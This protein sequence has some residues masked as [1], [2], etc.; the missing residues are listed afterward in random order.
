MNSILLLC[1][2]AAFASTGQLLWAS[3]LRTVVDMSVHESREVA[4]WNGQ[5][6]NVRV[7][8]L[9]ETRDEL[10]GAIRVARVRIAVDGNSTELE[11]GNY[12]L[13][14]ILGDIRVDCPVTKGFYEKTNQD[15]WGL[16]GKDVR[17]RFWPAKGPLLEPDT[18]AYPVRQRWFASDSQMTNEPVFVDGPEPTIG[19]REGEVYYHSGLDFD[20]A[21]GQEEILSASGGLVISADGQTLSHI[22]DLPVEPRNDYVFIVDN[23]GWLYW[24]GHL[25]SIEV[26]VGQ[27]VK[28]G[29][30]IGLMG[31]EGWSGG[32]S[33][34]HFEIKYRQPS[35]LWCTEDAYAYV[36]ETYV[37]QYKPGVLA[38]ARPHRLTMKG[39]KVLLDGGKSRSLAGKII[40]YTWLLSD[41]SITTGPRTYHTYEQTGTFS[42]VLRV[43]DDKGNVDYDFT[44]VQ[45]LA[46]EILPPTINANYYPTFG[47]EAGDTITFSV[48]SF[49]AKRGAEIWDFG[50]GSPRVTVHSDGNADPHSKDGYALTEH[51]YDKAG[52]YLVRV[53]RTVDSGT[54][55][56][57][58]DVHVEAKGAGE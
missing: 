34:L 23:R 30:R 28:V 47:I 48:R 17:L 29:E 49:A 53:E 15:R 11:S 6:V 35:G 26:T 25:N 33:H 58:L 13:P 40:Q 10:R 32:C 50:D 44:V 31:K 9:L 20:G 57:H 4:L 16:A 21:E 54:A 36:W 12:N 2:I 24:Y 37:R 42:E 56:A 14:L 19:A 38:V 45:V 3:P 46:G 55:V 51:T 41:G 1:C 52:L 22:K 39:Q 5:T 7:L 18:F 27:R 8:D 43:T